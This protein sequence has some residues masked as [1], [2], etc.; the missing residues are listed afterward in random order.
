MATAAKRDEAAP[1]ATLASTYLLSAKEIVALSNTLQDEEVGL[2]TGNHYSN[3]RPVPNTFTGVDLVRWLTNHDIVVDKKDAMIVGAQLLTMQKIIAAAGSSQA[4]GG[5]F[6]DDRHALY[7]FGDGGHGDQPRRA[8]MKLK[9]ADSTIFSKTKWSGFGRRKLK[10]KLDKREA[11]IQEEDGKKARK[12][13]TKISQR[14]HT[15]ENFAT[16]ET[17]L[18]MA[19]D[20]GFDYT[21]VLVPPHVPIFGTSD[22]SVYREKQQDETLPPKYQFHY[23]IASTRRSSSRSTATITVPKTNKKLQNRVVFYMMGETDRARSEAKKVL[24]QYHHDDVDGREE[25]RESSGS[26]ETKGEDL[27]IGGGG[28]GAEKRKSK[29]DLLHERMNVALE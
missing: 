18:E 9:R 19:V 28:E 23:D 27:S 11:L 13:L 25:I 22:G 29:M 1:P 17:A 8:R 15:A 26:G 2:R 24:E 20:Q 5:V 6:L 7:C 4:A 3:F 12:R 21:E 16:G 10:K 14:R